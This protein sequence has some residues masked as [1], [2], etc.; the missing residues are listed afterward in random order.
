[1]NEGRGVSKSVGV[2]TRSVSS[3]SLLVVLATV[4][5][6]VVQMGIVSS[7][8]RNAQDP[9]VR[10]GPAGAGNPLAGLSPNQLAFFLESKVE[11]AEAEE[12]DE[13]LGP[14]LNLDSCGGCHIQPALGGTSPAV[15]PQVAFVN[16]DGGTDFVPSFISANGPVR[17]ARFVRNPDGSPDGGV[18]ALFTITGRVGAAGCNIKQPD[19]ARE[20][21][22][23]N[24]IFRIPTPTFG[25]GLIEQISDAAILANQA[26]NADAK[27]NLGIHGRT[28]KV[29]GLTN[30]NG[31]DGTIARFGWKAQNIAAAVLRRSLQRGNGDHQRAVSDGTGGKVDLPV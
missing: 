29:T 5:F 28:N 31:N 8:G 22:N 27:N 17:E 23:R 2:K 19:F 26:A 9:G 11:F 18:H 10:K 3:A 14:R 6:F 15:N 16:Q 4:G 21:A 25:A 13:G 20:L 7:S 12:V 30:N 24:V 1:M